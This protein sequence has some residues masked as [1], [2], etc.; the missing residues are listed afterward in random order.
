MCEATSLVTIRQQI[1]YI[2]IPHCLIVT[3]EVTPLVRARCALSKQAASKS[4]K[5]GIYEQKS[6]LIN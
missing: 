4:V 3:Y 1:V 6:L 2:S 5:S